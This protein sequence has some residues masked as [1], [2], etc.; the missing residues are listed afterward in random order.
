MQKKHQ[1]KKQ[2]FSFK[3]QGFGMKKIIGLFLVSLFFM[4]FTCQDDLV[5]PPATSEGKDI[6]GCVINGELFVKNHEYDNRSFYA[7][8]S[9]MV[10]RK[11][12]EYDNM[13]G[14]FEGGINLIAK[15]LTLEQG[16]TY[17]L[18][19]PKAGHA[20]AEIVEKSGQKYT[21]TDQNVGEWTITKID[22]TNRIISGYFWFD[23][24]AAKDKVYQVRRGRFDIKYF[25]VSILD[26]SDKQ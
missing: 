26:N 5:L 6:F 8:D 1:F 23:I 22:K 13:V 16:K 3:K 17:P 24:A 9:A 14:Q 15:N 20:Y 21:T 10:Y 25:D 4:C 2:V 11:V 18:V 19:G 7:N 12:N